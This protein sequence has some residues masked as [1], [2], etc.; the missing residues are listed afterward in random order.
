MVPR[1]ETE[2]LENW[3]GRV[4][5]ELGEATDQ[6]SELERRDGL[7]E[8]IPPGGVIPAMSAA[9]MDASD[10]VEVLEHQ[11]QAIQTRMLS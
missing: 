3:M 5:E 10:R 8:P 6:E 11:M 9:Y 2:S 4:A 1:R 7:S